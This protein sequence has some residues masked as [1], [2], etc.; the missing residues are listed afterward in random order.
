MI[1]TRQDITKIKQAIRAVHQKR[2]RVRFMPGRNKVVCYSGVISGVYPEIF[3]VSPDD[4]GFLGKTAYSYT[5]ILCGE[6]KI[7]EEKE[8]QA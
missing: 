2:V 5:E 8:L 6:V 3:T 7:T 1:K 4:E